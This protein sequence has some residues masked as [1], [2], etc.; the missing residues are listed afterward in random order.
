[1]CELILYLSCLEHS[2]RRICLKNKHIK[3]QEDFSFEHSRT[4]SNEIFVCQLQLITEMKSNM[5]IYLTMILLIGTLVNGKSI[6]MM[7]NF[8]M[9]NENA[10]AFLNSNDN[11][12]IASINK[13]E[14]GR[15]CV[16]CKFGINPCCQPN[17][18]VK[19]TFWPDECMEIKQSD[20]TPRPLRPF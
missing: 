20:P 3:R 8:E 7:N 12:H 11:E 19:K 16:P 17:I 4:T 2:R 18:C 1:M 10:S 5:M 13:R 9:S 15:N 6:R 14:I